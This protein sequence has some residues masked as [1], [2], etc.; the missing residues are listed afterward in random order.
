M[1]KVVMAKAF[2]KWL[3]EYTNHPE[4]FKHTVQSV[5]E[6]LAEKAEGKEPTYGE[7]CVQILHKYAEECQ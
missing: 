6:A 5:L 3:D 1:D 2:N 7:E 4:R